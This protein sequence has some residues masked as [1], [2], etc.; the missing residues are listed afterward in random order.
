MRPRTIFLLRHGQTDFNVQNIVQGSG[1]DSDLNDA[2][3]RQAAQFFAAYGHVPFDKVYTSALRRT[4]Q[5]V[6]GF[7]DLGLPHEA[8]TALNE[9][10]WGRRE[11]SRI[12]VAEDAE[13]RATLTAWAAGDASA[14]LEGGESP[15]EVAARQRPFIELLKARAD[16]ETVLVCLHGRALRV[17]LCQ[18]L[19]Y[20]LSCMDGFEHSNLCLYKL[21][22]T[23]TVFTV[24]NFLDTAHLQS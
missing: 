11:G 3:R 10:S 18:L 9:I 8:H 6:Q 1:I 2:G 14:R 13:Y 20:P 12:T 23:G 15:A 5:S 4:R 21:E 17:L 24:K 7:L 16:E 22:Y 19:H